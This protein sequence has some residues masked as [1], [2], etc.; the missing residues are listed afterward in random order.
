MVFFTFEPWG[1]P[2]EDF[3][4]ASVMAVIV[5]AAQGLKN[6]I[7]RTIRGKGGNRKTYSVQ[8]FMPR[9]AGEGPKKQ[10]WKHMLALVEEL[11]KAFK[12]KDKRK[13]KKKAW[14]EKQ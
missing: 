7:V 11:N 2:A 5:N 1:T 4:N 8:D 9:Y 12:G 10:T 3:R 14:K 6:T 13:T